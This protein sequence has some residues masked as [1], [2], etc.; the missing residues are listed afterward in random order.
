MRTPR[1]R[2]GYTLIELVIAISLASI[3]LVGLF[4]I[5]ASM[6]NFQVEAL[7]KGTV[8]GWS[9]AAL[10]SMNR[11]IEDAS[12][13]VYPSA[14]GSANSISLCTNYSH[15]MAGAGG[16]ADGSISGAASDPIQTIDYCYD[17]ANLVMRR[18][19]IDGSCP[20]LGSAPPACTASN[21]APGAQQDTKTSGV[22]AISVYQ[23]PGNPSV[24]TRSANRSGEIRLRYVIGN[25]NST[26]TPSPGSA[27]VRNP[28]SMAFDTTLSVNRQYGNNQD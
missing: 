21:Y 17:P 20:V 1:S 24:F 26:T 25:P 2:A 9:L 18:Q 5:M 13:I 10:L 28:Q 3:V 16:S 23:A 14:G 4:A 8:N 12:V 15:I 7:K 6:M 19:V 11:E 22:I 27:M